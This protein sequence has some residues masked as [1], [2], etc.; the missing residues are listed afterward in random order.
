MPSVGVTATGEPIRSHNL[1][2]RIFLLI[3]KNI[4][5]V[6]YG[7]SLAGRK[8]EPEIKISLHRP[9]NV[10][11]FCFM[12]KTFLEGMLQRECSV[13]YISYNDIVVWIPIYNYSYR[14]FIYVS[15]LKPRR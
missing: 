8:K 10:W 13:C 9:F 2:L 12:F 15:I 11:S 6:A 7:I 14:K 4:L 5:N 1:E 3:F